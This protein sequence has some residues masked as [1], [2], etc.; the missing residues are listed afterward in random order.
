M[1]TSGGVLLS[2][3]GICSTIGTLTSLL[4]VGPRIL[5][6]MGVAEQMPGT[7]AHINKRFRT[8]DVSL[9]AFLLVTA[10]LML[11]SDFANLATM[12]AM[13]R[14]VTYAGSAIALLILRKKDPQ[15]SGFRVP[16]GPMLPILTVLVS[17]YLLSSAT[18]DQWIHGTAALI[19]GF[20]L[21][22]ITR[23]KTSARQTPQR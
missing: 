11:L 17:L 19:A 6:A 4:L 10:C 21:Y 3:G 15:N 13:A 12:S 18:K 5:F 16:G 14:L 7:F 20:L 1:G 8:P 9:L 22:G 23:L 2:A